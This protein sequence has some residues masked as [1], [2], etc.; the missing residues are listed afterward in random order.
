MP[1][2]INKTRIC[3]LLFCRRTLLRKSAINIF[4]FAIFCCV[5]CWRFKLSR[6]YFFVSC[7]WINFLKTSSKVSTWPSC[8]HISP[9]MSRNFAYSGYQAQQRSKYCS[10]PLS[11][12]CI[13]CKLSGK[14]QTSS[15][16]TSETNK[17]GYIW[18]QHFF[19]GACQE[20][21]GFQI[22]LQSKYVDFSSFTP[23]MK[24]AW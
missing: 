5:Q 1:Q 21:T 3:H 10:D 17:L 20:S 11:N 18:K 7:S 14:F 12:N 9:L 4:A 6:I 23:G 22:N 16:N 15:Q 8:F 2:N 19:M 13:Y 24:L